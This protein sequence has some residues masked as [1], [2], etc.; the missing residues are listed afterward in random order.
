MVR[1]LGDPSREYHPLTRG[2]GVAY[3]CHAGAHAT[4][5]GGGS[6]GKPGHQVT[7]PPRHERADDALKH[8]TSDAGAAVAKP[9]ETDGFR[10]V[11]D[12]LKLNGIDTIFGLPGIPITDLTRRLQAAGMGVIRSGTSR[13]PGTQRRSRAS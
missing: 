10:L 2:P 3:E 5:L 6:D 12:A 4:F 11:I 9:V 13:T 7:G 1:P 8:K